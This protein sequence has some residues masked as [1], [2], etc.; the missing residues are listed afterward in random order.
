MSIAQVVGSHFCDIFVATSG[1]NLYINSAIDNLLR[2]ASSQALMNA[3]LMC[4]LDESLG[5]PK[6]PYGLF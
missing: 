2:G 3:N 1:K 5:V 6:V 4:G